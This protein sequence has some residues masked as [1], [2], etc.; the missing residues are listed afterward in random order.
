[1]Q[2]LKPHERQIVCLKISNFMP[3]TE[4]YTPTMSI[5]F[6]ENKFRIWGFLQIAFMGIHMEFLMKTA[7]SLASADVWVFQDHFLPLS[8]WC[9]VPWLHVHYWTVNRS[10]L[11]AFVKLKNIWYFDCRKAFS[12]CGED[13]R[14]RTGG[15]WL[16]NLNRQ[17]RNTELD[18][19][20][21][22]TVSCVSFKITHE[23]EM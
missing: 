1:M 14:N 7:E 19:F 21:L 8:Y 16:V 11:S 13:D 6:S 9:T 2:T 15:R 22:E 5:T 10:V 18:N 23:R 17:Q 12:L 4:C 3:C 20:W